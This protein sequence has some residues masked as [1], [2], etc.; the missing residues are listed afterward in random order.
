MD[1]V[2]DANIVISMLI[3]HGKTVDAFFSEEMT[4]YAP[5]F[6]LEE[7]YN[8]K[9]MIIGKSSFNIIEVEE[10]IEL[11][12]EK[13]IFVEE[14][15]F[16]DKKAMAKSICPDKKDVTYFALALKRN[17]PIWS[18]ENIL[19]EQTKVK[20]YSTKDILTILGFISN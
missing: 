10:F 18:N 14:N 20:V 7:I 2:V 12:K 1:I 9:G 15:E 6:L 5:T 13:I 11:I 8:N 17:C 4:I 19:K 3:R 16:I